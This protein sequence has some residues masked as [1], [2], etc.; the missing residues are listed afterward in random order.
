M[1]PRSLL[2]VLFVCQFFWQTCFAQSNSEEKPSTSINQGPTRQESVADPKR[3]VVFIHADKK[4]QPL[5]KSIREVLRGNS[6]IVK[7]DDNAI[8]APGIDY[9]RDEDIIGAQAIALLI[10]PVLSSNNLS[11]SPSR[12]SISNPPG[13]IGIWLPAAG[14]GVRGWYYLGKIRGNKTQWAESSALRDLTFRPPITADQ[15][16]IP[17]I[18]DNKPEVVAQGYKYLR[19]ENSTEGKRVAAAV[20]Q[21]LA[22]GVRV[23]VVDVDGSGVDPEDGQT[24]LWALVEVL[25]AP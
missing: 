18:K 17:Q 6:Y 4:Y 9:F 1:M 16:I 11:L 7:D 3:Y 23:R 12:K 20:V 21:T 5:V 10:N 13:F 2:A 19:A 22:P 14:T 25:L 24:V 8:G 15:E